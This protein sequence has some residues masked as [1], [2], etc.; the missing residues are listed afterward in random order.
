GSINLTASVESGA[1]LVHIEDTGVGMPAEAEPGVGLTLVRGVLALHRGSME[2]RPA[3]SGQG[4]EVVVRL[5]IA[6]P[7]P[8]PERKSARP[9]VREARP[10][11]ILVADDNRDEADSL[12]RFLAL[13]GHDVR[14]S[15]GGAQAVSGGD[16]LRPRGA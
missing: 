14:V 8:L 12:E 1:V 10:L 15:Y 9:E 3:D 13:Y 2:I 11:R 6:G 5:P 16:G 4:T 7:G